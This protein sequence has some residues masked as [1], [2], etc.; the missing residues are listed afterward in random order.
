MSKV[1]FVVHGTDRGRHLPT[2]RAFFDVV[3]RSDPELAAQIVV[4]RTGSPS[5]SLNDVGLVVFWLGDPLAQK[6]PDCYLEAMIIAEAA[7]SR[8]IRILNHPQ[9]LNR[10]SKSAQAGIWSAA[11]IPCA[12][13][14]LVETSSE[15]LDAYKQFAGPCI[16]RPDGEHAQRG[17]VIINSEKDL[18]SVAKTTG[19]PS[20]LIEIKNVRDAYRT[21]TADVAS[22]F[23]Q[24]HHKA[25]AFVIGDE[26]KASHMLFSDNLIVGAGNCTFQK[27]QDLP[28]RLRRKLGLYPAWLQR[29]LKEDIDYF[30]SDVSQA[31]VLTDAVRSLGLDFAAVDYCIYPDGQ[32]IVWE[33]NPYFYLPPGT[34]SVMSRERKAVQRV[35][36]SFKWMGSCLRKALGA[37]KVTDMIGKSYGT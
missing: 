6:Y 17:I 18:E 35:E 4:H 24:F 29:Q 21:T 13:A 37:P 8:Q 27:P 1:L 2:G 3:E 30:E 7:A 32:V 22:P 20:V 19:F 25:R 15:L 23:C 9:S 36:A 16:L 5:P 28:G 12:K 14:Q 33:A 10:T 34:E 31:N 11:G 26:V